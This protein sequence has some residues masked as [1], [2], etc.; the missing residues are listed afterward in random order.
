M[1]QARGL[2]HFAFCMEE[3]LPDTLA[4][5]AFYIVRVNHSGLKPSVLSWWI[6]Q[7]EAQAYLNEHAGT[8]NLSFISI[9]VL[10]ALPVPVPALAVQEK[11]EKIIALQR[12]EAGLYEELKTKRQK[13]IHGLCLSALKSAGEPQA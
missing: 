3:P 8:S 11:I 6:N 4:A 10:S 9:K 5:S 12:I 1:F 2:S 7:P 13:L